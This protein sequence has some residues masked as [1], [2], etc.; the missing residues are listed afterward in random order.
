MRE[1]SSTSHSA[2]VADE[3]TY[4]DRTTTITPHTATI[5]GFD[6]PISEIK[7]VVIDDWNWQR[8]IGALGMLA[9]GLLYMKIHAKSIPLLI[10]SLGFYLWG[11]ASPMWL[12]LRLPTGSKKVL[13]DKPA[14][15]KAIKKHVEDAKAALPKA[16]L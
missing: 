14:V 9:N 16:K 11:D 7:K 13:R 12:E 15:L 1:G 3:V 6:Y 10:I 5:G 4:S 2:A 8:T